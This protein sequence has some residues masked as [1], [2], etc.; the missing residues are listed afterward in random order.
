[1]ISPRLA[2]ALRYLSFADRPHRWRVQGGTCPA[3]GP[4]LFV[5]LRANAFMTRCVRCRANAVTLALIPVIE[6]Q[7]GARIGELD[8]YELSTF[9]A[10][11][12][13]MRRH[14][15]SVATSE[16]FPASRWAR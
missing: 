9:G 1:M 10:S 11:L 14:I 7:F 15:A 3:C 12:H 5:C 4:T 8:G 2:A 6:R 13:W 16:F